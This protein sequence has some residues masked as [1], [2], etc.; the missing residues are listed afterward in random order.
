MAIKLILSRK[1]QSNETLGTYLVMDGTDIL[2]QCHCLELPQLG[3]QH[4]VSC[5]PEGI[6]NVIKYSY[7]GHPNV[8]YIQDVPDRTGIMIHIGNFATGTHVDT[9][10]CQLPGMDF[11]D[12]DGN[13]TLDVVRP[14]VAMLSLNQFLPNK[15]KLY[16]C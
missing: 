8:F 10:G 12:I 2:F 4:D 9:H 1:Y 13:G 11:V 5:I 14:D 16:I 6:Y 7:V 15:F 3:N